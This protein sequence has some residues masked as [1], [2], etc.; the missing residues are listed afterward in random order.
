MEYVQERITTLH[1]LT[2]GPVGVDGLE[3]T[4]ERTAIIVPMT[5]REHE[6]PAATGVLS[7][8][9]TLEPRPQRVVVP[10]RAEQTAIDP[11]REWLKSFDLPLEVLWCTAPGVTKVLE[12][13]DL[14][15]PLG[16][17]R[18]IWLALGAVL[19]GPGEQPDSLVIH[20][21][22]AT[23][24][25]ADD[26]AK[27]LHPIAAGYQFSKGYYAR[28][29]NDQLYGRL[30]RLFYTPLIEALSQDHDAPLLEYL[31]AFRYAL[32]GE[33]AMTADLARELRPPRTWGLEVATLGDTFEQA[34][35]TGTAQVDLGVHRHDHRS[36]G[37]DGGLEGMSQAVGATLLSVL[38]EVASTWE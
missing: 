11:L 26:V 13:Q 27:L 16:K 17:G 22:D 24:F 31:G 33:V 8:L 29:E 36:V 18:D 2:S 23:S 25:S 5:D 37:G 38:T 3:E 9:E 10:V 14:D 30:C 32:S 19:D 12:R 15:G 6:S 7:A 1:Q 4:L 20:D 21:A 35:F 34:G 28:V